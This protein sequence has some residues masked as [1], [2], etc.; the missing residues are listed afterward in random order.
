MLA[1]MNALEWSAP[2]PAQVNYE[3]MKLNNVT[4]MYIN[5]LNELIHCTVSTMIG[6][7]VLKSAILVRFFAKNQTNFGPKPPK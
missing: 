6:G 4:Y 5:K 1:V 3:M 2:G 7:G